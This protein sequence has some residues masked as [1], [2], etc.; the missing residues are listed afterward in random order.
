MHHEHGFLLN[1]KSCNQVANL[2]RF[3]RRQQSDQFPETG[4]PNVRVRQRHFG[5][6]RS[7]LH[8]DDLQH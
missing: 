3:D 2:A 6:R 8:R 1:C 5:S 4:H 7:Q